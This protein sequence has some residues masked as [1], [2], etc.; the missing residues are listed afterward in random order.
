MITFIIGNG[1]DLQ[2]E[3][4]TRYVDFYKEYTKPEEGDSEVLSRFKKEILKSETDGWKNWVDFEL[5]LGKH[6]IKFQGKDQIDE[7]TDC[8]SDFVTRFNEYLKEDVC[9]KIDWDSVDDEIHDA[10]IDSIQHFYNYTRKGKQEIIKSSIRHRAVVNFL[11]FNYTD[12]FSKLIKQGLLPK[13]QATASIPGQPRITL[14]GKN[15]QVHGA[16][17]EHPIMGVDNE[18]QIKNEVIRDDTEACNIFVKPKQLDMLES[19]DDID[20]VIRADASKMLL[21]SN[22]ICIFGAS[23]GETDKYWWEK[24]GERLEN[25]DCI[26]VIFDK[27]NI[28]ANNVNPKVKARRKTNLD[29]RR[30]EIIDRLITLS[31][32]DEEWFE[33][34]SNRI[35]VE[36]NTKMFDFK[37]PMVSN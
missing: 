24:I 5:G 30:A 33:K 28:Q 27:Y 18:L 8:F 3:L 15:L 11:Q 29:A 36:L 20:A 13:L 26:I 1:F 17:D 32:L 25:P 23:I 16:L 19:E 21:Q 4:K 2:L 6:S 12:V 22:I 34:N 14:A 7:F 37:M 10:F 9:A 35:I 31:G